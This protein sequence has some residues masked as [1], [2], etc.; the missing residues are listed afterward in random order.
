MAAV[1]IAVVSSI[2]VETGKKYG[3]AEYTN[4]RETGLHCVLT[5][6][7]LDSIAG[8]A[9]TSKTLSVR[10]LGVIELRGIVVSILESKR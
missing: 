2:D 3:G 5:E 4:L 9:Y 10:T 6:F 8:D 1:A 7:N